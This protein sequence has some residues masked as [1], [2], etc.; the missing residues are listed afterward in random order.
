M[1]MVTAMTGP[2]IPEL[3]DNI[4]VTSSTSNSITFRWNGVEFNDMQG[5]IYQ[6]RSCALLNGFEL[7]YF[8]YRFNTLALNVMSLFL[9]MFFPHNI[10]FLTLPVLRQIVI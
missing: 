9:P 3:V 10:L 6:V 5:G 2:G 8:Y 7:T 1:A 4:T